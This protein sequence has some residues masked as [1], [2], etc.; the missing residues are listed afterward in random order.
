[1]LSYRED[2]E[3]ETDDEASNRS[4]EQLETSRLSGSQ[5]LH[6]AFQNVSPPGSSYFYT[7]TE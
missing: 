4:D 2:K 6:L 1:M 5:K 3:E 7:L